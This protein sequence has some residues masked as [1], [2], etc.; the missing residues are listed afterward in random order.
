M[1]GREKEA[2]II[3][4]VRSNNT[5][6]LVFA[7]F[8]FFFSSEYP[9]QRDVGFLKEKKRMNGVCRSN[10]MST[11]FLTFFFYSGY[12]T[13]KTAFSEFF[14]VLYLPVHSDG[15][16]PVCCWRFVDCLPWE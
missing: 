11:T 7:T 16:I 3:S 6:R 12:D 10:S 5:V 15:M 1:Q 14:L 8:L 13:S 9:I 2:V 4:L